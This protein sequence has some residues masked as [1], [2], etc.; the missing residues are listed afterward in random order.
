MINLSFNHSDLSGSQVQVVLFTVLIKFLCN[1]LFYHHKV[2]HQTNI[3]VNASV[4]KKKQEDKVQRTQSLARAT[5]VTTHS[6][7]GKSYE[8]TE[9]LL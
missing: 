3:C 6:V 8:S 1:Y 9:A 2:L 5:A 7:R 4:N